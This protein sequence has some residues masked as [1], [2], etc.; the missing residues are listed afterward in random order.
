VKFEGIILKD[1][2][3]LKGHGFFLLPELPSNTPN[4]PTIPTTSNILSGS[5]LFEKN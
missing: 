5:V 4:P 3:A 1:G 2:S